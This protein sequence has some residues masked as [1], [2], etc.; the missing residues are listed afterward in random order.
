MIFGALRDHETDAQ[1]PGRMRKGR[2]AEE[3]TIPAMNRSFWKAKRVL[4]TGHTG[5]KG[6]WLSLWLESLG[7]EVTGYALPPPTEPSMFLLTDAGK[8]I[9]SVTGDV[10][11]F[12]SLKVVVAG[13]RPEIVIHMAAQSVVR[14]SYEHPVETYGT[15]VMGTVH[16]LEALRETGRPC[17]VVNVTSDKCYENRNQVWGY[18]E[19]EPLG[20]HD[21]YSNSK[22][23]SELV[24]AAYRQSYF[25]GEGTAPQRI[26]VAT[27]RAGNVVG[28]GDW[29]R[30]QLIPDLMRAF[31]AGRPVRIRHPHAIRP[32]QF[33]LEAL[34]GY[35]SLAERL[36]AD[37]PA[38]AEAWNFGPYE[39]DARPVSWIVERISAMWG[40]GA[41]WETDEGAHPHE[42]D[43]LKLDIAKARSRLQWSPRL[44]LEEAIPWIVEWYQAYREG[45]DL[46]TVT[47]AQIE[48]Y[49]NLLGLR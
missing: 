31:V 1:F 40:E 29:T 15:N 16:L 21:P 37:G 28:G 12:D 32:W 8:R 45:R 10:R 5:F 4:L 9:D 17:V 6:S 34:R 38:F 3:V 44:R 25:A 13:K 43:L 36:H 14:Y 26:A 19:T 42:A 49:E 11:D 27:G 22:A 33:V 48:R 23:C 20:G 24:T 41:R 2:P 39:E 35:L 46:R 47:M 18:R 7:A 30:D